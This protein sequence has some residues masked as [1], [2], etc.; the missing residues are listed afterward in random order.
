M[1]MN[2]VSCNGEELIL[3]P[4]KIYYIIDALY[5]NNI[6]EDINN[7]DLNQLDNEIKEKIFP[8]SYAPFAKVTFSKE[9]FRIKDIKKADYD[10]LTTE[11]TNYFSSDTGLILLIEESLF[12]TF[13]KDYD[14]EELVDSMVDVINYE[15]WKKITSSFDSNKIG[16]ILSPGINSGYEFEGSGFYKIIEQL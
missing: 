13:I 7:L 16:L 5:L 15:Y 10:E 1:I 6:K 2:N 8:Y 12:I 11:D 9:H 14:Y 4:Y 3:K